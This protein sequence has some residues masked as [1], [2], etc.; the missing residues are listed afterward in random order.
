MGAG[1]RLLS[2][3]QVVDC[4]LQP[5]I[6]IYCLTPFCDTRLIRSKR[7]TVGSCGYH[8]RILDESKG[9]QYYYLVTGPKCD[10]SMSVPTA[11]RERNK[12]HIYEDEHELYAIS[13][14]PRREFQSPLPAGPPLL[15]GITN[16]RPWGIASNCDPPH[17]SNRRL[18]T[19]GRA[20]RDRDE[21]EIVKRIVS[22][23][24]SGGF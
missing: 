10:E 4:D 11:H 5:P 19:S 18:Q 1:I 16:H 17:H 3:L 9:Q 6:I 14:H 12:R 21:K 8:A 13:V 22:E 2:D 7:R 24:R 15:L 20:T 23:C